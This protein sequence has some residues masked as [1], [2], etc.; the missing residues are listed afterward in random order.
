VIT[1]SSEQIPTP[2]HSK[3]KAL[4]FNHHNPEPSL[5]QPIFGLRIAITWRPHKVPKR[6][7][8]MKV[9]MSEPTHANVPM[10]KTMMA[11]REH[12]ARALL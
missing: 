5:A 10:P 1:R 7:L 2:D 9:R 4:P 3:T 6:S 11:R 12:V 8:R